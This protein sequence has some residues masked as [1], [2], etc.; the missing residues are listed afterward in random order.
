MS[1]V[2]F[3]SEQSARII[4]QIVDNLERLKEDFLSINIAE[5]IKNEPNLAPLV[6]INLNLIKNFLDSTPILFLEACNKAMS[7]KEA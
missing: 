1:E 7:E 3:V 6:L 5:V 4:G 2:S